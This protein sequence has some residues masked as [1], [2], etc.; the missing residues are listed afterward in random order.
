M[1]SSSEEPHEI[2]DRFPTG[3]WIGFYLQPDS[4]QRHRMG[5]ALEFT[6][7]RIAGIGDD[8]VG[9]FTIRGSYDTSTA[10]CSWAKQY[11]GK[12]AVDYSG[13]ARQGGIIGH[14]SIASE[15]AL[16]SGPFFIW[17][18]AHGELDAA[19]ERA[20]LEYEL[21]SSGTPSPAECVEV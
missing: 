9:R 20:F 2:D 4:R 14:W 17:P 19:F 10:A 1:T 13:Q 11:V 3:E 21:E 15:P 5:L 8:P 6:E 12:H 18:K 7:G 16:W